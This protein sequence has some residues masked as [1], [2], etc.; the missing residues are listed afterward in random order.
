MVNCIGRTA[1]EHGPGDKRVKITKAT[2]T[3]ENIL[4]RSNWSVAAF[5]GKVKKEAKEV[6][7]KQKANL[8]KALST[9]ARRRENAAQGL[10]KSWERF[11]SRAADATPSQFVEEAAAAAAVAAAVPIPTGWLRRWASFG[12]RETPCSCTRGS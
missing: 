8:S 9:A 12:S 7:D 1:G 2:Q 6:R 11:H 5:A 4:R 3:L 10:D